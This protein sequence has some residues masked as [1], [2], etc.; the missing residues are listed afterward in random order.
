MRYRDRSGYLRPIGHRCE[1]VAAQ[2]P[3]AQRCSPYEDIWLLWNCAFERDLS[4]M[5]TCKGGN[6]LPIC[7]NSASD[8]SSAAVL[9]TATAAFTELISTAHHALTRAAS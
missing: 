4:V 6:S 3:V 5:A 8:A 2:A 1:S 7:F 9:V